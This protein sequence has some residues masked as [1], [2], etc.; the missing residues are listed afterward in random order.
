MNARRQAL[1][2]GSPAGGRGFFRIACPPRRC[3]GHNGSL[4]ARFASCIA[5][6]SNRSSARLPLPRRQETSPGL[7][8]RHSR[9]NI[10]GDAR[11][12]LVWH[13]KPCKL[14][15][16]WHMPPCSPVDDVRDVVGKPFDGF[17]CG[18]FQSG[19]TLLRDHVFW[20]HEVAGSNP[21]TPICRHGVLP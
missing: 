5:G 13:R 6:T 3:T 7:R 4:S 15:C 10:I 19:L 12:S 1:G 2:P 16:S 9:E 20:D 18:E 21:V 17:L 8:D 14:A 11:R